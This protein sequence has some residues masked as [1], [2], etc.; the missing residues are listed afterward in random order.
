MAAAAATAATAAAAA[1]AAAAAKSD[2]L[3]LVVVAGSEGVVSVVVK[4][5]IHPGNVN[6]HQDVDRPAV[7]IDISMWRQR[8]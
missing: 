2:L 8:R 5:P 4:L 1:A 7:G 3:L 6:M